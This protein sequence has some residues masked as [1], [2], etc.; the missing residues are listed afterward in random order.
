MTNQLEIYQMLEQDNSKMAGKYRYRHFFNYTTIIFL[1][2]LTSGCVTTPKINLNN[3]PTITQ[4]AALSEQYERIAHDIFITNEIQKDILAH[5]TQ[6]NLCSD[7]SIDQIQKEIKKNTM[8]SFFN[9]DIY[10]RRKNTESTKS[11]DEATEI[12]F[13]KISNLKVEMSAKFK[14]DLYITPKNLHGQSR[15]PVR[16]SDYEINPFIENTNSNNSF[17]SNLFSD[18]QLLSK[19]SAIT[20]NGNKSLMD[21]DI[22]KCMKE[23]NYC[24]FNNGVL[25][26]SHSVVRGTKLMWEIEDTTCSP[27]YC[28]PVNL[29]SIF[30]LNP[31]YDRVLGLCEN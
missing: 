30:N 29:Q 18:L 24:A 31:N 28:A 19:P 14:N 15:T 8:L 27:E 2:G 6:S 12:C 10:F 5:S 17:A 9:Y 23:L 26:Y 16:S 25:N 20:I 4:C 21:L 1:I 22:M 13:S 7:Y 11:F 3:L